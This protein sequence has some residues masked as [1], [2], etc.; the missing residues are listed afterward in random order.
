MGTEQDTQNSADLSKLLEQLGSSTEWQRV[1]AASPP[2]PIPLPTTTPTTT[3]ALSAVQPNARDGPST[4]INSDVSGG[5]VS[6]KV[7]N[8]LRQ[9]DSKPPEEGSA[10]ASASASSHPEQTHE[11][12]RPSIAAPNVNPPPDLHNMTF[13]QALPHI[14]QLAQD[15]KAIEHLRKVSKWPNRSRVS[16]RGPGFIAFFLL[17]K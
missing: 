4:N 13:A 2:Q 9:L 3:T 10:S 14:T 7:M 1:V 16:L 11:P 8:L 5:G 17:N 12:L 15:Q 6:D